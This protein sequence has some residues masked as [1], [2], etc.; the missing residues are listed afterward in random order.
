MVTARA[1]PGLIRGAVLTPSSS[2]VSSPLFYASQ[3]QLPVTNTI[4]YTV[5]NNVLPF[6]VSNVQKT[7]LPITAMNNIVPARVFSAMNALPPVIG[8]SVSATA[9]SS[10][11]FEGQSRPDVPVDSQILST[12]G[13]SGLIVEKLPG[14]PKL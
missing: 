6:Y 10:P 1:A 7:G 14:K 9:V 3:L 13:R 12:D 8:S 11:S 2:I 4:Q 5:T